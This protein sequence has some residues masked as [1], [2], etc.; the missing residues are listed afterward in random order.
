M[1]V[2]I[3]QTESSNQIQGDGY[4]INPIIRQRF[5][6]WNNGLAVADKP[7]NRRDGILLDRPTMEMGNRTEIGHDDPNVGPPEGSYVKN[8]QLFWE[9]LDSHNRDTWWKYRT[10]SEMSQ[11]L[12]EDFKCSLLLA[13]ASELGMTSFQTHRAFRQFMRLDL[14][15]ATGRTE[16]NSFLICSIVIN[17]EAKKFDSNKVYHPQ[18]PA[19]SKDPSFQRLEEALVDRFARVT[20]SS[21]TSV[22]N[23]LSQ[24]DPPTRDPSAW[25]QKVKQH[26]LLPNNP[27]FVAEQRSSST[28]SG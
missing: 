8:G 9:R 16:L 1:S 18:Q 5:T 11:S 15:R 25:K 28:E 13:F 3:R 17:Q 22:Y 6:D 14:P 26:S 20:E 10:D 2:Q 7:K 23:K 19:E 27:S 12:D 21:L 24:G 4:S